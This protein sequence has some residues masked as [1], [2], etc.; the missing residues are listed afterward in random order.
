MAQRDVVPKRGGVMGII[1]IFFPQNIKGDVER[2]SQ[3]LHVGELA[4]R[5]QSHV[6]SRPVQMSARAGLSAGIGKG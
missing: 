6:T 4:P 5:G 2:I 3:S 1:A